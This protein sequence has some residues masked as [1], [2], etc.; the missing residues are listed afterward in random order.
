VTRSDDLY[1][2]PEGLPVPT[3]DGA[4]AH[5][6]GLELPALSLPAT[7]GEPVA[8]RDVDAEWLVLYFY[9]RTGL[10]DREP[11]GG[12]AAWDSIP[13]TRGCTPQAC[14]YR[15]HHAELRAAGAEVFGISTQDTDYQ[16]EAAARLHLPFLLLSDASFELTA[17]LR[18]PT[19]RIEGQ[20]LIKR[21]TLITRRA[22]IEE[23][24]YPVFP[25]DADARR[26]IDW[27][28]RARRT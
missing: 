13:G 18:L 28:S 15:D 25:P 5:L 14:S 12:L 8:L 21:L 19:L 27:L 26:V 23:C 1:R 9:P 2:L 16:R 10:P 24:F 7:T 20:T 6:R 3:D 4:C 11:P 22:R 17:A